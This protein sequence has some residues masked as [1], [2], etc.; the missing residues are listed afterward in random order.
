[1]SPPSILFIIMQGDSFVPFLPIVLKLISRYQKKNTLRISINIKF[2][3]IA[4]P[5]FDSCPFLGAKE[6]I[7]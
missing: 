5:S 2:L 1:M 6:F 3:H 7:K 4:I